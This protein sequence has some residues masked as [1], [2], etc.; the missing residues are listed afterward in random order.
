MWLL[1]GWNVSG[2]AGSW[3]GGSC[4]W[5]VPPGDRP[6]GSPAPLEPRTEMQLPLP[7][8][9]PRSVYHIFLHAASNGGGTHTRAPTRT[10]V[11]DRS[12]TKP[13]HSAA[14]FCPR[15]NPP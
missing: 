9:P 8:P 12:E 7:P 11:W 6:Y 10:S 5:G 14:S 13:N 4:L 1:L 15:G 3:L 2:S